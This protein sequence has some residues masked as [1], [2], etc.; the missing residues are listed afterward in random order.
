[1]A[2]E[3]KSGNFARGNGKETDAMKKSFKCSICGTK[4]R[5]FGNNPWPVT[6][7]EDD[8]CCDSCDANHVVPARFRRLAAWLDQ[9]GDAEIAP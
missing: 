3:G 8:R 9:N 7:G 2:M 1:M 5:G 4:K 6:T